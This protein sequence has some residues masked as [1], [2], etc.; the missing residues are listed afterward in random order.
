MRP[1]E[2]LGNNEN[3]VFSGAKIKFGHKLLYTKHPNPNLPP[4]ILQSGSNNIIA[5]FSRRV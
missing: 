5:I 3:E 2:N 4:Q 1:L